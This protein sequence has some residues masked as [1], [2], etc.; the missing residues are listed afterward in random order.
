MVINELAL[1]V[2]NFV[3]SLYNQGIPFYII[4]ISL[5]IFNVIIYII[6]TLIL[7]ARNI[8]Y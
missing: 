1:L 8:R 3:V 2:N 6:C 5:F 4:L 7:Q